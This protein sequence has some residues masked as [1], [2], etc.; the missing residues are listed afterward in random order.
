MVEVHQG[1]KSYSVSSPD[2]LAL[3]S[4][5]KACGYSFEGTDDENIMTIRVGDNTLK[6]QLLHVLEFNSTR[7]RMSVI[8]KDPQGKIILFTKG[9]DSIVLARVKKSNKYIPETFKNLGS[10]GD[11][12]L[13][14]LVYAKKE[15]SESDFAAWETLYKEACMSIQDRE[16]KMMER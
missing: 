7:K 9:A 5:A 3:V 12:G 2:E 4:F 6:Y 13:R 16:A 10:F 15:L 11:E 1:V 14:T 8:L